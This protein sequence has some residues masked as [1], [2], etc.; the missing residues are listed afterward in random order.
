MHFHKLN[1]FFLNAVKKF[2]IPEK[3]A[4]HCLPHSLSKHPILNA[5]L[6][7]KEQQAYLSLN[8]FLKV[9]Q[10]FV[11]RHLIEVLFLKKLEN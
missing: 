6:K 5:I 11:F 4:D 10:V 2:N 8:E 7:Y 1:T 3:L 9:F